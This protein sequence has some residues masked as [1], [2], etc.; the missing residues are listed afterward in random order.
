LQRRLRLVGAGKGLA[1]RQRLLKVA[2]RS[3]GITEARFGHAEVIEEI[4]RVGHLCRGRAQRVNS[5][6]RLAALVAHPAVRI[7][8]R[9]VGRMGE[10]CGQGFRPIQTLLI[11]A[12]LDQQHREVV[13]GD[14]GA[15]V[16][17]QLRL[18]NL[19]GVIRPAPLDE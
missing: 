10:R 12:I 8:E 6:G 1:E 19:F 9:G 17:K 15:W 11:V 2:A 5:G 4:R 7:Q 14:D 13:R 3:R 18:I 16:A